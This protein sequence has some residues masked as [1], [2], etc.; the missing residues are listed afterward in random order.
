[1]IKVLMILLSLFT[2]E[3]KADDFFIKKNFVIL[4]QNP[5]PSTNAISI[6]SC[7]NKVTVIP[8]KNQISKKWSFVRVGSFEGYIKEQFLAKKKPQCFEDRFPKFHNSFRIKLSEMYYW[9]RL[10]HQILENS[11][12]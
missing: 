5:V 4:G 12:E 8:R 2:Y 3:T 9:A 7:G 1:M 10:N 6:L 11:P